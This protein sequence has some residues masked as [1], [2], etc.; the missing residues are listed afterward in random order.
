MLRSQ[1]GNYC[2]L[3]KYGVVGERHRPNSSSSSTETR[4]EG[5]PRI[6]QYAVDRRSKAA[7]LEVIVIVTNRTDW[8]KG[9]TV[10]GRQGG[11]G[12]KPSNMAV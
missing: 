8:N 6:A 7:H 12:L 11:E 1:A 9:E 10:G 5:P 2:A 4:R 3:P